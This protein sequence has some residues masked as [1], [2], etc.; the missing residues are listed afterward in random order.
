MT[1]TWWAIPGLTA[2]AAAFGAAVVLL[3]TALGRSL[4]RRLAAVLLL[5]AAWQSGAVLFLLED[6][7]LAALYASLAVAALAALPFQY[8][9]FLGAALRTPLVRPFRSR[10]AF[11]ILAAASVSAAS[12]LVA[13]PHA[14][15][16]ELYSPPWATWNF[17]FTEWGI[18]LTNVHGL[19]SL[20]GLVASLAALRQAPPGSAARVRARWFAMAFGIRDVVTAILFL[21]Y[22]VL[23]PLP[24]WGDFAYNQVNG[25]ANLAYVC[26]LAYGVL[27][28]Q[29]FDIDLRLKIAFRRGT[30]G[31]IIGLAFFI[32]SEVLE[33]VI[34]VRGTILG[35]LAAG[36]IVLLLRPIQR[37][38]ERLA[39]RAMPH[40]ESTPDYLDRQKRQ[41]YRAALEGALEDGEVTDRERAILGRLAEQLGLPRDV[42]SRLE[43]EARSAS[44]P[45]AGRIRTA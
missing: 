36:V 14:F 38:A 10:V 33:A 30:V 13:A 40:V 12:V 19:V 37:F 27:R 16:G 20:F 2:T 9:S 35:L 42:T 17:R 5:E 24:F 44:R 8:L 6:R 45:G 1:W 15:I 39:G 7:G 23:R 18:R 41:V 21:S 31:S 28:V 4:N 43:A 25:L 11:P 32:G 3:R 34:P 29:L 22:P 26:L